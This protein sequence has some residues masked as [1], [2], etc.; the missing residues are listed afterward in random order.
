MT[1]LE[2]KEYYYNICRTT[3]GY[4][5]A[6][7]YF[8]KMKSW[9]DFLAHT[10]CKQEEGNNPMF[11]TV[12]IQ[13]CYQAKTVGHKQPIGPATSVQVV[14]DSKKDTAE[15]QRVYLKG[16]ID[17]IRYEKLREIG[18]QFF[19][20]EPESPKTIKE[21]KE[22]LKKGLY[23]VIEPKNYDE[24][25]EDTED[26]GRFYWRDFFS[27]RTADTQFDK[28]GYKAAVEELEKFVQDIVDQIRILDPKD[29][30]KL[31]ED[32]KKWK[33]SKSKK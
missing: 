27:W 3:E 15:D 21:L 30:L 6:W 10:P 29:G 33:P 26:Y 4:R 13:E 11:N 25:D 19:Y 8:K 5:Q 2:F 16:R 32:L 12:E 22:R 7:S 18:K 20:D 23:T 31:L 14:M 28:V 24:D 9:P 1:R 17:N